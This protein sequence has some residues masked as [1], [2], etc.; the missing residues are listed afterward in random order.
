MYRLI[1]VVNVGS[2][3]SLPP[4]HES[5]RGYALSF[6]ASVVAVARH[7]RLATS[8]WY[9]PGRNTHN[10]MV[11]IVVPGFA[12]GNTLYRC[13]SIW[14][15]ERLPISVCATIILSELTLCSPPR[16]VS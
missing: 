14:L 6:P 13:P 10:S 15:T 11:F 9:I 1:D 12:S 8:A 5:F 4:Y 7:S 2:F 3:S 16:N